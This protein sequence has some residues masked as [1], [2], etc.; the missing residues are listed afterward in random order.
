MLY[1]RKVFKF[2]IRRILLVSSILVII[3]ATS[4]K[5]EKQSYN[6]ESIVGSWITVEND[7]IEIRDTLNRHRDSNTLGSR[8]KESG[9]FV[10][11]LDDTL[12]F[13]SSYFSSVTNYE[14]MYVE[15]LD[16]K[17]LSMSDSIMILDPVNEN[18][19]S[20][21]DQRS[22]IEFIKQEYAIDQSIELKK[23]TFHSSKCFGNCP[24]YHLSIDSIGNTLLHKEMVYTKN[25]KEQTV[26]KL[27]IGYYKGRIEESLLSGLEQEVRSCNLDVLKFNGLDCCDGSV[28][29]I[30][31]EYN[32]GR[33]YLKSMVPPRIASKLIAY[34]YKICGE[35]KLNRVDEILEFEK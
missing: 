8:G 2:L 20:L 13:Q 10:Y 19:D 9:K 1:L 26:D 31:I 3:G 25:G 28:V 16:F 23:I 17:I 11:L 33:K 27:Q 22:N 12:R 18:A 24:A 4:C 29:T 7:F 21:F 35:V 14:N 6:L 34:L 5:K 30:I 15:S 32:R